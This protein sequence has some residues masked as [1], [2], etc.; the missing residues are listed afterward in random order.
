MKALFADEGFQHV[1]KKLNLTTLHD[2]FQKCVIDVLVWNMQVLMSAS[3][4]K[5]FGSPF[6]PLYFPNVQDVLHRSVKKIG[7]L[8]SCLKFGKLD[9]VITD[10]G[11]TRSRRKEWAHLFNG[12]DCV[13]FSAPLNG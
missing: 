5:I 13:I 4:L 1:V 3:Y 10:V 7:L 6:S 12:G 2:H 9:C 8:D 11:S